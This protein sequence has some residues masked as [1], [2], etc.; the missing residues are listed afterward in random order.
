MCLADICLYLFIEIVSLLYP[1]TLSIP[2]SERRLGHRPSQGAVQRIAIL[3]APK[4]LC[5]SCGWQDPLLDRMTSMQPMLSAP[6]PV[7]LRRPDWT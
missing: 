2:L 1:R 4:E 7:G 6:L 5:Y 3:Q